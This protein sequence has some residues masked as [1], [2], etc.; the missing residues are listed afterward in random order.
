MA[1]SK[2]LPVYKNLFGTDFDYHEF[3]DRVKMQKAIYLLQEMGVPVG[4]YGFHWYLRGPYSQELQD[5]MHEE[6]KT[7]TWDERIVTR[8]S[9]RLD[10]LKNVIDAEEGKVYEPEEW[11]E[12][13]ASVHYLREN[14]MDF[15][16]SDDDIIKELVKRSAEAD[17]KVSFK[18]S[19]ANAA[20]NKLTKGL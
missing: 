4:D 19:K 1:N 11:M 3:S 18:D 8:H 14:I 2:L 9:E 6:N 10:A 7:R 15:D 17:S 13:L 20:A 16:A 12:C 5:D